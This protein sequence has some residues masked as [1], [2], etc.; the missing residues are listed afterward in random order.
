[1]DLWNVQHSA[2]SRD[3]S[4]C[5][6]N[7][8]EVS[9]AGQVRSPVRKSNV[10]YHCELKMFLEI[11]CS[12]FGV[13]FGI[14]TSSSSVEVDEVLGIENWRQQRCAT[15]PSL[16]FPKSVRAAKTAHAIVLPVDEA[17]GL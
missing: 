17:Q 15:I 1:M 5:S 11:H 3:L 7:P 6:R 10:D 9:C 14:G 16:Y 12:E 2:S 13:D 8:A 4:S